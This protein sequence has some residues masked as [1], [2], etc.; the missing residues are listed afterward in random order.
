MP[1]AELAAS[2]YEADGQGDNRKWVV[3]SYA[4]SYPADPARPVRLTTTPGSLLYSTGLSTSCR[5]VFYQEGFSSSLVVVDGTTV[6]LVATNFGSEASMTGTLTGTDVVQMAA[7]EAEVAFLS[8]G[9]LYIA[10]DSSAFAAVTDAD[11][12][13]LLSDHGQSRFTSIDS[14]G[15]R[16][17]ATYGSRFCFSDA[18][19]FDST[20]TLSYYTAESSP[21][22]LVGGKRVGLTYWLGGTQTIEPW[23]QTGDN[24]DPFSPIQV[25]PVLRGVF[26]HA[27]MVELDNTLMFI[28]DDL[29]LYRLE[30]MTPRRLDIKDAWVTRA[31][32]AVSPG[33]IICSKW[34]S[35]GHSQ[36]FINTPDKCIVFDN[37]TQ[38]FHL[39]KTYGSEGWE[40]AFQARAGVKTFAGSR[41]SAKLSELSRAYKYDDLT[42][43][44]GT[45]TAIIRQNSGH[46][47]V[48]SGH[49]A[50]NNVRVDGITGAGLTVGQGSDPMILLEVS[51]DRGNTFGNPRARKLG[52][53]GEYDKFPY[54]TRCGRTQPGQTVLRLTMSE[55][56]DYGVTTL[57]VNEGR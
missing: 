37:A 7:A 51:T 9:Q 10:G 18:G 19:D 38:T 56:V 41:I 13:T 22:P 8:N 12:A 49:K 21:D 1:Q 28:G 48:M 4:E 27:S 39:R 54:W 40:W 6:K 15:Q 57:A 53:I 45:G 43:A 29:G 32:E 23:V 5:G 25:D 33:D 20:T 46:L 31:L 34:E 52:K 30:G 26:C 24:D 42:S 16:L 47:P 50:L 14:V 11:Y 55:P 35:Q 3:N 2:H 36:Y 17:L 44:T